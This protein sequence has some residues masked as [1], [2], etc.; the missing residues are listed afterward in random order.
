MGESI[1]KDLGSSDVIRTFW[2]CCKKVKFWLLAKLFERRLS[3]E[4]VLVNGFFNF[5]FSLFIFFDI[6]SY[7]LF[8]CLGCEFFGVA[9]G[10]TVV[11][12]VLG[13]NNIYCEIRNVYWVNFEVFG[14]GYSILRFLGLVFFLDFCEVIISNSFVFSRSDVVRVFSCRD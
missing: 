2:V 10:F 9:V 14:F 6:V 4:F 5:V 8:F 1:F 3:V 13:I 11:F 7:F 12:L